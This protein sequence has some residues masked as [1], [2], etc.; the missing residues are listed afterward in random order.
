MS[1][2]PNHIHNYDSASMDISLVD[3]RT[4][5]SKYVCLSFCLSLAWHTAVGRKGKAWRERE[6][7]GEKEEAALSIPS[8]L[9]PFLLST[10]AEEHDLVVLNVVRRRILRMDII[11]DGNGGGDASNSGGLDCLGRRRSA[12][13]SYLS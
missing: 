4:N 1:F 2:I 6:A 11:R 12:L 5:R 7:E 10:V 9:P 13:A 8:A 3:A